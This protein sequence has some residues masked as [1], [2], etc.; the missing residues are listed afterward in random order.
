MI[1]RSFYAPSP[2]L[3]PNMS[4]GSRIMLVPATVMEIST[5]VLRSF[6]PRN[7]PCP[8]VMTITAG[9]DHTRLRK[10]AR[11][12]SMVAS[13]QPITISTGVFSAHSRSAI[14]VPN[15]RLKIR[16]LRI[17]VPASAYRSWRG[18]GALGQRE[19]A[20]GIHTDHVE[21]TLKTLLLSH[22][23][24]KPTYYQASLSL[25]NS[26]PINCVQMFTGCPCRA[27]AN[28]R[29]GEDRRRVVQ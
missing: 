12:A 28:A 23:H 24:I 11:P 21:L 7:A 2:N 5:V 10:Y 22:L 1:T 3:A 9:S 29:Q 20:R 6:S 18:Q 13:V 25:E 15:P 14:S 27:L 4:T 19:V 8:T 17:A 16:A 26:I